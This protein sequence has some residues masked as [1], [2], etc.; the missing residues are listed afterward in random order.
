MAHDMTS[1]KHQFHHTTHRRRPK[2]SLRV[3]AFALAM[4][5]SL[6]TASPAVGA[7]PTNDDIAD[8]IAVPGAGFTDTRNTAEATYVLERPRLR[9]GDRVVLVHPYGQRAI[10]LRHRRKQLRHD[11]GS[12]HRLPR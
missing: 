12:A 6:L 3:S 5:T 11:A 8:A 7:P 2:H 1:W 10:P 4:L 9:R